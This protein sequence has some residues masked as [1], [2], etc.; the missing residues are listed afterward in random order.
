MFCVVLNK[1]KAFVQ[2]HPMTTTTTNPN[3][4]MLLD[5]SGVT[6]RNQLNATYS[7]FHAAEQKGLC[8]SLT[9]SQMHLKPIYE[10]PLAQRRHHKRSTSSNA[11]S[12]SNLSSNSICSS[13]STSTS[14]TNGQQQQQQ[15]T[16]P[17]KKCPSSCGKQQEQCVFD[18]ADAYVAE[19]LQ[20]QQ[21]QTQSVLNRPITRSIT[22]HNNRLGA[23]A[24]AS[25]D[26]DETSTANCS[27]IAVAV[28]AAAAALVSSTS[29][30]ISDDGQMGNS[31]IKVTQLAPPPPPPHHPVTNLETSVQSETT[32]TTKL[33]PPPCK[34]QKRCSTILI[35]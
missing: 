32:T 7:A 35:D 9:H 30:N 20:Q 28:A 1:K 29:S 17:T 22:H 3:P 6:L 33:L 34:R 14:T 12:E 13:L 21:E 10:A 4:V 27:A 24:A 15:Y 26:T 23:A 2:N 5:D 11:S 31:S 16:T 25:K 19:Y 8:S 18:F